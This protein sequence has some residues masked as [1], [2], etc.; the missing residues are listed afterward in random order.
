MY[1]EFAEIYDLIYSFIDYKK[2]CKK[3]S[4]LIKKYKKISGNQLLDVGCGTGSHLLYLQD[5][6]DCTGVDINA[7]ML[8][9]AKKKVQNATFIQADMITMDLNK[10]FDIIICLF[11]SIGYVKTYENLEKTIKNFSNHLNPG[12]VVIIEPWLS[13]SVFQPGRPSMTTYDG[14]NIKIARLNTTD[15]KRDLSTMEMHYLVVKKDEDVQYCKDYHELGLFDHEKTV[16]IMKDADLE[17]LS[18]E[19]GI[20]VDRGLFIGIKK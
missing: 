14:E 5:K 12:G 8:S 9:V 1:K 18:F 4:K 6:F 7:K 16:Q 11:S 19:K 15:M 3:L 2:S 10:K 13:A 20:M 17:V